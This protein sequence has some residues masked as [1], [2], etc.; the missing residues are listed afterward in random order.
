MAARLDFSSMRLLLVED[1]ALNREILAELLEEEGY[2][3][4]TAQNGKE[5]LR[6][7]LTDDS[8]RIPLKFSLSLPFGTIKGTLKS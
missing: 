7:T 6:L 1:N 3:V 5:A 2:L 8:R 4:E